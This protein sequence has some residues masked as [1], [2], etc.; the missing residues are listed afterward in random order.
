M[1]CT[2]N[3]TTRDNPQKLLLGEP[4]DWGTG[5]IPR[6]CI[7]KSPTMSRG[8]PDLVD[9]ILIKHTTGG[10]SVIQF[11]AYDQGRK[12][13]QGA[14]LTGGLWLDEEPP[15]DIY[16]ESQARI[17][18]TG[19]MIFCTMTPLL[20]I[21]E[22]VSY[23][24]PRPSNEYR[25]LVTLE[26]EEVEHLSPE[27]KEVVVASYPEHEREARA[28]GIPLLGEGLVFAIPR[29]TIEVEPFSIPN[30]WPVLAGVDFG[31]GDH[32]FAAAKIAIDR[33][34]DIL[35]L[36]NVYAEK[37]PVPAIH[38]SS[39]RS[40]GEQTMFVWPHDGKRNW[41]DSGP[42][43]DVYRK[44]GLRMWREH[45]T[46]KEGGYSPEA[47]A[48][49]VLTRM[50]TGRFKAFSH[51]E[52]FWH[53]ISTYHRKE[54][55]LVQERDDVSSSMFKTVMMLRFARATNLAVKYEAKVESEWDEFDFAIGE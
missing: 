41:G 40:W 4:G 13:W 9:H 8:F 46:F 52:Q 50:Q 5:T 6:S 23:F 33:D 31:Y 51:L 14:T 35:Y 18:A 55:V 19:G 25:A 54:G 10:N 26:I 15:A 48:Q 30:Y 36:T 29:S 42:V 47:A 53:E 1:A 32:P 39:L 27:E 28:R 45:S 2:T 7:S 3:E 34:T 22:V 17:A 38:V 20:G 12:R 43:A 11:K 24:Y 37:Q 44:E 49:L 21:S 16:S